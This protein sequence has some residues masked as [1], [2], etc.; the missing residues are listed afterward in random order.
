MLQKFEGIRIITLNNKRFNLGA[1]ITIPKIGIFVGK[2]QA[3]NSDLLR[4]EFGHILQ[5]QQK[6]F[7]YFWFRIAPVSLLSAFQ[8]SRNTNKKHMNTWTEWTANK[9]SYEYFN[10]PADW[11]FFRYPIESSQL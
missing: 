10:H 3:N 9:L 6:G 11:N 7:F 1:A 8:A 4:H 5:S 2:L